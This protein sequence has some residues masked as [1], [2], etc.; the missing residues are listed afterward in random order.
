[1][2]EIGRSSVN[3]CTTPSTNA[4]QS[5]RTPATSPTSRAARR[6]AEMRAAAAVKRR[7]RRRTPLSY[8]RSVSRN[9]L[10]LGIAALVLVGFAILVSLVLPRRDPNFPGRHM[11]ALI[12]VAV[13]LIIT[14]LTAVEVFGESHHV[15]AV[16]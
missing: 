8:A 7:L 16:V 4:C 10:I 12:L 1:E 6:A 2:D 9:D 3:P 14:M 15:E 13:L 11:G 5:E